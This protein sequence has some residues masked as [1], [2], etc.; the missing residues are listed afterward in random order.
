MGVSQRLRGVFS[1]GQDIN[2]VNDDEL[3]ETQEGVVSV[4]LD[5]L[6]LDMNDQEL[7]DLKKDWEQRYKDYGDRVGRRQKKNEKYWLGEHETESFI[8]RQ[9]KVPTTDASDKTSLN[10]NVLFAALETFLPK[11]TAKGADPIVITDP[12]GKELAD[13]V[14]KVLI[15]VAD[16]DRLRLKIKNVVRHWALYFLGVG[17]VGWDFDNNEITFRKIR[18]QRMI[19]DPNSTIEE[20]GFY[21][22]EYIGEYRKDTARTLIDRFPDKRDVIVKEVGGKLGTELQYIEWWGQ[23]GKILFWTLKDVVLGKMLNPHWNYD[24]EEEQ[25]MVDDFGV[26][27]TDVV[28]V[29]GKNH[30][31]QPQFPYIFLSVFNVGKHPHDDTGL[32]EQNIAN[33]E[34]ITKRYRQIDQNVDDMNGGW[35]ISGGNSGIKKEQAG[36]VIN[37]FRRGEGVWIPEGDVGNAV[38]RMIGSGLP[39]DVFNQLQDAR[40]ELA[41]IFGVSGSTPEGIRREDT[42]R[43][44]IIIGGQDQSRIGWVTEFIEQFYD[45]TYNW[46]VQL[47]YVYYDEPHIASI[48][49]KDDTFE[50]ITLRNSDL[51]RD[52]LVSVKE[53]SMIPKDPVTIAN[54][55]IDLFGAGAISL[56]ELHRRLDTPNPQEVANEVFAQQSGQITPQETQQAQVVE[57]NLLNQVPVENAI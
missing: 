52:L 1:L 48:L 47:M 9:Y 46:F 14:R 56:I 39:A 4:E 22:G 49:G 40:K 41:N 26:E 53:G 13:N 24:T 50:T 55:A 28:K 57:E 25:T 36:E 3:L 38:Q 7:I 15:Y 30:F 8:N 19:L 29:T 21:T 20:G 33:Q 35:A 27:S 34:L 12:E 11:A 45:R 16:K 32:M 51:N 23:K 18:P 42:V 37:A 2:K 54:Q 5:E 31:V 10:D 44:K 17:K 6:N 43:G